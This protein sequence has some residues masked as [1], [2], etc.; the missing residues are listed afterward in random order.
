[1][2]TCTRPPRVSVIMSVRDG[3]AFVA[4]ALQSIRTQTMPDFECVV[5]DDGSRDRTPAILAAAAA[6]DARLRVVHAAPPGGLVAALNLGCA[7]ARAPLLARMDADDVALPQRLA[8][9]LERLAHDTR[10]VVLGGA[11]LFVDAQDR[12]LPPDPTLTGPAALDAA[13][14]RGDCPLIHP[15]V[16][17]RRSAFEAVGGYRACIA[18]AE[19]YDLWL[20]LAER[21]DLDNLREPVLRYRRHPHQ[22]SIRHFREQALS[23]LAARASARAR[24]AGEP[25]PLAGCTQLDEAAY[26]RLGLDAATRAAAL[27]RAT[28]TSIA[29]LTDAGEPDRAQ[30][31]LH[32]LQASHRRQALPAPLLADLRLAQ[33]R[34]HWRQGRTPQAVHAFAQALIGRPRVAVRPLKPWLAR[35]AHSS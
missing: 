21:G 10:L 22:V 27:A 9:Q 18:H 1:M 35:R 31:L 15:T 26:E 23:N 20:R 11:A 19:D 12:L 34:L 7:M 2:D 14:R 8:Q 6:Q 28:L 13:L 4:A 24:R 25:D 32:E 29:S 3:E 5:V 33:A 17:M 16:V 30:A